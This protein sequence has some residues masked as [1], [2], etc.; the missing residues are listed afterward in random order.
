M[1]KIE[2]NG[3]RDVLKDRQTEL[4]DRNRSRTAIAIE[5]SAD[6]LD[7]IQ[8]GQECDLAIGTLDRDSRLLRDVRAAL[9]RIDTGT[10]G[11]C[12]DC[13]EDIS[14]KRL[15]A[16]PWKASCIVCQEAA[17]RVGGRTWGVAEELLDNAA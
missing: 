7:R 15:A 1:T 4:E 5:T 8:N 9:N 17:D 2:L 11:V 16:V 14:M 13:E 10:F 6:E 3:F 12:F